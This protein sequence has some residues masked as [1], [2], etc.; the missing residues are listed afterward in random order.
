MLRLLKDGRDV[1]DET[2]ETALRE[3]GRILKCKS[4]EK[5]KLHK[6]VRQR[7]VKAK[8]LLAKGILRRFE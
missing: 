4:F 5:N 8:V 2:I 1:S 6:V 7:A 3:Y